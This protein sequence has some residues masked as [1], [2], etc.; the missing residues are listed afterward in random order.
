[1][2]EKLA[3]KLSPSKLP[4][5]EP[6]TEEPDT[7]RVM[8]PE[9]WPEIRPLYWPERSAAGCSGSIVRPL[10]LATMVRYSL[11]LASWSRYS[12]ELVPCTSPVDSRFAMALMWIALCGSRTPSFFSLSRI[13]W[14]KRSRL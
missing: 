8:E 3:V 12:F 7:T 5:M 11:N 10:C 6:D 2:P 9:A 14:V 4:E 1:M 13:S